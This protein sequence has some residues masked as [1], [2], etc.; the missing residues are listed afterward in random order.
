MFP[1]IKKV[2]DNA[3]V[4]EHDGRKYKI[5]TEGVKLKKI[6]KIQKL[7][8]KHKDE[9]ELMIKELEEAGVHMTEIT[10]KVNESKTNEG[11]DVAKKLVNDTENLNNK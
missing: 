8:K 9:P 1:N 6:R 4:I 5:T 11:K 2:D 10:D 7:M 3:V